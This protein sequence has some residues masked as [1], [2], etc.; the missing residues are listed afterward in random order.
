MD[1]KKFS[2]HYLSQEKRIHQWC[3]FQKQK[4]EELEPTHKVWKEHWIQLCL[5]SDRIADGWIPRSG[6]PC[7]PRN[8]G[9]HHFWWSSL[10]PQVSKYNTSDLSV[11][12][13]PSVSSSSICYWI[14]L[15]PDDLMVPVLV[16]QRTEAA[17]WWYR[18]W[19]LMSW[20]FG[21]HLSQEEMQKR[22][23][24]R[25]GDQYR[26]CETAIKGQTRQWKQTTA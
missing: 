12:D 11:I 6:R 1:Q 4:S 15:G 8:D 3:R 22:K 2:G 9:G 13:K 20:D 14:R 19:C 7:L 10:G 21:M 18:A 23:R 25:Q 26:D 24:K 5:R 17:V 16:S